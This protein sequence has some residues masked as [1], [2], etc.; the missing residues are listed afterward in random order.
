MIEFIGIRNDITAIQEEKERI[1]DRLG[2]ASADSMQVRH[3]ANEY[4][5]AMDSRSIF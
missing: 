1:R 2:I 4:E 3:S 5:I